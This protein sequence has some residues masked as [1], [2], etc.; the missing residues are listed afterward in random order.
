LIGDDDVGVLE[1]YQQSVTFTGDAVKAISIY[2]AQGTSTSSLIGV[3]DDTAALYRLAAA[4][5]WTNGFPTV[6]MTVGTLLGVDGLG[7]GVFRA[8]IASTIVTAANLHTYRVFPAT[9]A[10]LAV[11]NVGNGYFGGVMAENAIFCGPYVPTTTIPVTANKDDMQR[12]P[13]WARYG[14][15]RP[16]ARSSP[17]FIRGT[18]GW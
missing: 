9:D 18:S 8:R 4:I 10:A 1:Y 7:N 5:T 3:R 12:S 14:S 2:F 11:A 6:T 16:R 17:I 13:R 15:T